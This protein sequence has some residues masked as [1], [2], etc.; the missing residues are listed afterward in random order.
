MA[1][2][3]P[4]LLSPSQGSRCDPSSS[5]ARRKYQELEDVIP[6]QSLSQML[7]KSFAL[8]LDALV[9]ITYDTNV[10]A[11]LFGAS[12][13]LPLPG[14]FHYRRQSIIDT[15]QR[16]SA[17]SN[18]S[19]DFSSG[20]KSFESVAILISTQPW[21]IHSILMDVFKCYEVESR[22]QD[23]Q[24]ALVR[25]FVLV[26]LFTIR[27]DAGVSGLLLDVQNYLLHQLV[28]RLGRILRNEKEE[29]TLRRG[30]LVILK[31]YLSLWISNLF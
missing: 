9:R 14:S 17:D 6:A 29:L 23:Q 13:I 5:F 10:T 1:K 3:L 12:V 7:K 27:P 20:S 28:H 21:Q 18:A 22:L 2:I 11:L 8:L 19:S 25:L 16:F 24:E 26:E 30:S 15:I 4:Q 31:R